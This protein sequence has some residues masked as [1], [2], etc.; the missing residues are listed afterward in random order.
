[1][2][3]NSYANPFNP[4]TK[5]YFEIRSVKTTRRVVF[6]TLKVYDILG[7][8]VTKLVNKEK[9][10]GTYEI[11]FSTAGS[12]SSFV[13]NLPAGRQGLSSGIYISIESKVP[14]L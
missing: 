1:M 6:K 5:I 11:E 2:L 12:H 13:W 4:S 9:A 14:D 7:K 10:P 8:E 3:E